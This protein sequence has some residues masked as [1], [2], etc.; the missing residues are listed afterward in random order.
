MKVRGILQ[1]SERDSEQQWQ[2]KA[3]HA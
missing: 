3:V 2:G 1:M